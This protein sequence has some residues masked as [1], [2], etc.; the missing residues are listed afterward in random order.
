MHT[1]D[2]HMVT[3]GSLLPRSASN[4]P[5]GGA[6]RWLA[7]RFT[8][9]GRD[10]DL[11]YEIIETLDW[12][13]VTF[14][15]TIVA[16]IQC[17]DI[18]DLVTLRLAD[19]GTRGLRWNPADCAASCQPCLDPSGLMAFVDHF[20]PDATVDLAGDARVEFADADLLEEFVIA[21]GAR[22]DRFQGASPV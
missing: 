5:Q 16:T 15:C 9:D 20:T 12:R 17:R 19:R 10:I 22:R 21:C 4:R 1:D 6:N 8:F 18:S 3:G 2:I 13:S 14:G 11:L 7:L